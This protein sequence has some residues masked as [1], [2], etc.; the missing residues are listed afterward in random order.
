MAKKIKR[1]CLMELV[2]KQHWIYSKDDD[3]TASV[4]LKKTILSWY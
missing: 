2:L 1:H 4:V 3:F